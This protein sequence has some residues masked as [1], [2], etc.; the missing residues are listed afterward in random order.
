M[1]HLD[2]NGQYVI[3]PSIP[4]AATL[5]PGGP[6]SGRRMD[7]STVLQS[8]INFL[9]TQCEASRCDDSPSTT[10]S[11]SG[12]GLSPKPIKKKQKEPKVKDSWKPANLSYEEFAQLML[13]V[14][15]KCAQYVNCHF[16]NSLYL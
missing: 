14:S 16:T 1:V 6:L 11:S 10:S 8:A 9:R 3:D 13:E 12:S 2:A 4:A 7:K 15:F 5:S